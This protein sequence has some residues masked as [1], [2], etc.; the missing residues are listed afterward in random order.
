MKKIN[1]VKLTGDSLTIKQIKAVAR[2][3]AKVEIDKKAFSKS[4]LGYNIL[5]DKI[6]QKEKIYGVTTGFGEFSQVFIDPDKAAQL[7]L[8]LIRSHSAGVGD[9]AKEDVVRATMLCRANY[10]ASGMS[11]GRPILLQTLVEMLNKKVT[12]LILEQGSVGSSGDLAPLAMMTLPMIGEGEAFYEGKRMPGKIAMKKAGIP[13]IKLQA[14]EGLALINGDTFMAGLGSLELY[15]ALQI[16]KLSEIACAMTMESIEVVLQAMD[17]KIA[18]ARKFEGQIVTASNLRKLMNKSEILS[19]P[20]TRVQ[21]CYSIRCAPVILGASRESLLWVKRQFETEINAAQDN[22]LVFLETGEVLSGG[23]FHGQP[24]CMPLETMAQAIQEYANASEIRQERMNNPYYS[25]ILPAFLIESG[26]LNSGFMMPQYAS[27]ALV[28]ENKILCYPGIVD[29]IPVSAGQEDDC[30]MGTNAALKIQR[31]IR[32]TRYVLAIELMLGCQAL[33]F[34]KGKK[35]GKGIK[36]AYDLIRNYV[37]YIKVDTILY[38]YVENIFN[39]I[40]SEKLVETVEK[41]MGPLKEPEDL[42]KPL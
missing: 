34:K 15:D 28:N 21:D 23:N 2:D 42:P 11:G 36:A 40:K 1:V 29:S 16:A 20:P 19:G 32:N 10:L 30:S 18:R 12:P 17:E 33:D 6:N 41:S 7:Q 9:P 27:A 22:P 14:K 24:I 38:K 31:I 39:L 5:K 25:K 26:G 4:K 37:P 8:N 35:P 3:Y 13:L